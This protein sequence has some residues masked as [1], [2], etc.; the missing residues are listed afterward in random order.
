MKF[1]QMRT[2]CS[3]GGCPQ[4]VSTTRSAVV[5]ALSRAFTYMSPWGHMERTAA[6]VMRRSRSA[7]RAPWATKTVPSGWAAANPSRELPPGQANAA[8]KPAPAR[9]FSLGSA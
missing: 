2:S 1:F 4:M 8:S 3:L 5:R 7:S 6:A 9:A